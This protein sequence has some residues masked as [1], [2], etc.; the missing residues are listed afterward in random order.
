MLD[1]KAAAGLTESRIQYRPTSQTCILFKRIHF[2]WCIIN[3][4]IFRFRERERSAAV[5]D[6]GTVPAR[7]PRN[8]LSLNDPQT[9]E[10]NDLG[11]WFRITKR[12]NMN[13]NSCVFT[14]PCSSRE[15]RNSSCMFRVHALCWTRH[16]IHGSLPERNRANRF[17]SH[18]RLAS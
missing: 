14:L 9:Y 13:N 17:N 10:K 3:L 1:F 8:Y 11:I 4:L 12:S 18:S 6:H 15:S 5:P 7:T 2:S 16:A